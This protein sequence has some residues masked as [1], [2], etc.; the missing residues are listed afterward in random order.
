MHNPS[1]I[2]QNI[3]LFGC[4][5]PPEMYYPYLK[6][7]HAQNTWPHD[8]ICHAQLKNNKTHNELQK[9]I[10]LINNLTRRCG[11]YCFLCIIH[12]CGF[13]AS[14]M[15]GRTDTF[16]MRKCKT[17]KPTTNCKHAQ[18]LI[19]NIK[20]SCYLVVTAL[21]GSQIGLSCITTLQCISFSCTVW[22]SCSAYEH[23]TKNTN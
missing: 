3:V 4:C 21:W 13:Y 17:I 6:I 1:T 7:L 8:H 19:N 2:T 10:N 23:P 11:F 22:L 9:D 18:P 15:H 12:T 20:K 14:K 16:V 5:T